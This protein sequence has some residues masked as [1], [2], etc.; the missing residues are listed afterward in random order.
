MSTR[1]EEWRDIPGFDGWY[2]VSDWGRIRSF[3]K[4]Y[5]GARLETPVILHTTKYRYS[6]YIVIQ[7]KGKRRVLQV[8]KIVAL[9]FLGGIPEGCVTY[10]KD[11]NTENNALCNIG[12]ASRSEVS[13]ECMSRKVAGWNR[14]PVLK[15]NRELEVVEAYPSRCQAAR[16]NGYRPDQM[17]LFCTLAIQFSVFAPDDF[18]YTFDDDKWVKKALDR[19]R[20]ELDAMNVRYNDPLT[21]RYYEVPLEPEYPINQADICWED[22]PSAQLN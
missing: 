17:W 6:T 9:A 18:I 15:I 16:A 10:H 8:S 4:G 19:A 2:Q 22:A 13:R 20:A 3:R 11:G 7:W 14:R 21:E 1:R 12:I 5:K